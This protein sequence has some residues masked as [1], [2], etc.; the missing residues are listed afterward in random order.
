MKRWDVLNRTC[1]IA[2][3]TASIFKEHFYISSI[4]CDERALL[5]AL[6]K[7]NFTIDQISIQ[8]HGHSHCTQSVYF[9]F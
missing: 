5:L 2:M 1:P 8:N 7:G 4:V 9:A 3:K 6:G